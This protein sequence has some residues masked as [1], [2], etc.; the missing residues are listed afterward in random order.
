MCGPRKPIG[1]ELAACCFVFA[2]PLGSERN[3]NE[4]E[5][6]FWEV[7]SSTRLESR[8][9]SFGRSSRLDGG[10]NVTWK[11]IDR[12][13]FRRLI[14]SQEA[15]PLGSGRGRRPKAEAPVAHKRELGIRARRRDWRHWPRLSHALDR[16][17]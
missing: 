17:R 6:L 10:K 1:R 3:A 7:D 5:F 8:A 4:A 12:L 14:K 16:W 2:R 9:S 15:R 13:P 11:R